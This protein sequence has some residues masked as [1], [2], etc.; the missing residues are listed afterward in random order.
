ML[1]VNLGSFLSDK[2]PPVCSSSL[3]IFLPPW[4]CSKLGA[5]QYLPRH[6]VKHLGHQATRNMTH[7]L[8]P[9]RLLFLSPTL[10]S[11][12]PTTT[13]KTLCKIWFKSQVSGQ[14]SAWTFSVG[15]PPGA[16]SRPQGYLDTSRHALSSS[17]GSPC[18]DL[19]LANVSSRVHALLPLGRFKLFLKLL[20]ERGSCR[21]DKPC[22]AVPRGSSGCWRKPQDLLVM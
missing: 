6:S 13:P 18:P 10:K 17:C 14:R 22:V 7:Q 4:L 19:E 3:S 5:G 2:L 12:N 16:S 1:F 11:K 8:W 9:C 15:S 20:N 21:E